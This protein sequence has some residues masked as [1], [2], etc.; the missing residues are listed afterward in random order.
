M[1][2]NIVI[3]F[4]VIGLAVI[5]LMVWIL[6]KE[7][8]T[9]SPV[10]QTVELPGKDNLPVKTR[11]FF[12][13]SPRYDRAVVAYADSDYTI[14]YDDVKDSFQITF[15]VVTLEQFEQLR[16]V[17]E[18]KLLDTL[19]INQQDACRLSV[20]EVIPDTQAFSVTPNTFSLSFCE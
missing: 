8:S 19:G 18:Q 14:Q 13:T 4:V 17:A 12:Q 20:T 5:A 3:I 16:P 6:L 11:D 2:K 1:S 15:S 9:T 7:P 10:S